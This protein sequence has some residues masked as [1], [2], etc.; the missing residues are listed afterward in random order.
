[1]ETELLARECDPHLLHEMQQLAFLAELKL[2]T[3]LLPV[4]HH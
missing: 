1:M 2:L 3:Q 4:L